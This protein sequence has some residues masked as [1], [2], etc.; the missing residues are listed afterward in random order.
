MRKFAAAA[1]D[2]R[3]RRPLDEVRLDDLEAWLARP[4]PRQARSAGASQPSDASSPGPVVTICAGAI[5]WWSVPVPPYAAVAVFLGPFVSNTSSA[6]WM[7]Q[8]ALPHNRIG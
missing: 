4:Q 1:A 3:F 5:P 7:L 8:S 2:A 6:P